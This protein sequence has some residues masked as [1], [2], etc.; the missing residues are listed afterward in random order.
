MEVTRFRE[1]R[2]LVAK[3]NAAGSSHMGHP[4]LQLP[5]F[6]YVSGEMPHTA[7]IQNASE[8]IIAILV[9]AYKKSG[10]IPIS[11][12]KS[13]VLVKSPASGISIACPT[14]YTGGGWTGTMH[15]YRLGERGSIYELILHVYIYIY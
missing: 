15:Q 1:F 3:L 8:F 11:A 10:F 7:L 13:T 2:G 14:N 12:Y 6:K 9:P 4:G 5:P